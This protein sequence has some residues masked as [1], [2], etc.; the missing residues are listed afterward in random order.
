MRRGFTLVEMLIVLGIFGM[1]TTVTIVSINPSKHL[2]EAKNAKRLITA[3][4]LTNALNEYAI[5]TF[6]QPSD[7][8]PLGE[9][10]AK[11]ICRRGVNAP[12]C[13]N[14]DVIVPDFLLTI[15]IDDDEAE[16]DHT[17]FLVYRMN[18]SMDINHIRAAH[19]QDCES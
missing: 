19:A 8:I 16:P 18:G 11:Q 15:P 2:C 1:L 14:V 3:R 9:V 10:Q 12:T 7:E 17:G 13:I 6:S 5:S 4:E